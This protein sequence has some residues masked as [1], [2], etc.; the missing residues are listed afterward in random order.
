MSGQVDLPLQLEGRSSYN[1]E[2]LEHVWLYL[3]FYLSRGPSCNG[4]IVAFNGG[5]GFSLLSSSTT[6]DW[7]NEMMRRL[8]FLYVGMIFCSLLRLLLQSIF[9]TY[10]VQCCMCGWFPLLSYPLPSY[11][12]T[13]SCSPFLSPFSFKSIR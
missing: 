8:G 6:D 3:F 11:S 13:F 4:N 5:S 9:L 2:L 7:Y 10:C 1:E 12:P